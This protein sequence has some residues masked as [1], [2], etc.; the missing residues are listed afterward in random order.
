MPFQNIL[1]PTDFS[2]SAEAA[3][4]QALAF[5]AREQANVLLLHVLPCMSVPGTEERQQAT[6]EQWLWD[7]ASQAVVPVQ[8]RVVWG[9]PAAEICRVAKEHHI[10]LIAMSTHGRTGRALDLIGSVADAVI[11]HAPC[12]VLILRASLFIKA[13]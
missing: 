3:V 4:Q 5:A 6:T 13:Q 11:R 10:D 2:G 12:A 1:I 7:I 8:T 9:T